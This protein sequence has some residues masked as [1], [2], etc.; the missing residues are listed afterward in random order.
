ML[1]KV[2]KGYFTP[3]DLIKW[4]KFLGLKYDEIDIHEIIYRLSS[5]KS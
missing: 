3:D 4:I 1:D 2:N 5:C